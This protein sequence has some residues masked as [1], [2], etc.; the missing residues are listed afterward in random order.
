MKRTLKIISAVSIVLF[1]IL[2]ILSKFDFLTEYNSTDFRTFL[3]LLYLFT[4]LNYFKRE[5]KDKN[6]EIQELKLKL[7]QAKREN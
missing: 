4:S 1:G 3:V 7:V 5:V 6:A 2:W